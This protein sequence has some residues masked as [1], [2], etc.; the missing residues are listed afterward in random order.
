MVLIVDTVDAKVPSVVKKALLSKHPDAQRIAWKLY[1][2]DE[3]Q[4]TYM[5]NG[6][7]A[8]IFITTDGTIVESYVQ[9]HEDS[10]PN[11]IVHH[12]IE[13]KD[14]TKLHY[15]LKMT[16]ANDVQFYRTKA[17]INDQIYELNFDT[18]YTLISQRLL[19]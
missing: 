5:I 17:R 16:D 18:N 12:M 2:K 8:H 6:E 3:Y 10:I 9:L 1:L 7:E 19:N 14:E 11:E 4:A 13:L 15:V